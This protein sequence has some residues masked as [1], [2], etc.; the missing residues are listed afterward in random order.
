MVPFAPPRFLEVV[1]AG[2][3]CGF[4][5]IPLEPFGLGD[6]SPTAS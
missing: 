1:Q 4:G 3:A 5:A 6:P 2:A